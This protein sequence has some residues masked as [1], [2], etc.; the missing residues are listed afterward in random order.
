M[1]QKS[2]P[3]LH[4][5][6]ALNDSLRVTLVRDNFTDILELLAFRGH[7]VSLFTLLMVY[8]G[9]LMMNKTV[10]GQAENTVPKSVPEGLSQTSDRRRI[11]LI[12]CLRCWT[13]AVTTVEN[14]S[15][16]E[17][18]RSLTGWNLLYYSR[19][20]RILSGDGIDVSGNFYQSTI[21]LI[22][23]RSI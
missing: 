5:F 15:S 17:I 20:V 12:R 1:N 2:A 23:L 4:N 14:R 7:R 18:A 16:A 6:P 11:M 21:Q 8:G 9:T 13:M 22:S 10:V 19:F 3:R